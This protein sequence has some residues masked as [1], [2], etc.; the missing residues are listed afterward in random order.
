[1]IDVYAWGTTN[2]LRAS[3]L[4]LGSPVRGRRHTVV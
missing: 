3:R 2:G 1:M 4:F